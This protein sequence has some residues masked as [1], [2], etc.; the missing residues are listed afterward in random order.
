[1]CDFFPFPSRMRVLLFPSAQWQCLDMSIYLRKHRLLLLR[2]IKSCTTGLV[3]DESH[4]GV[5]C[6]LRWHFQ[7]TVTNLSWAWCIHLISLP[8]HSLVQFD[9]I[10]FWIFFSLFLFSKQ[11][12]SVTAQGWT[13][14]T[15]SSGPSDQ[16]LPWQ[17]YPL[18]KWGSAKWQCS[19]CGQG[20]A[21]SQS[22]WFPQGLM[23]V[24]NI[25]IFC[26]L[27]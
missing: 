26:F 8:S 15:P 3:L 18:G 27:C 14:C 20:Q 25:T 21:T 2:I 12:L 23:A 17:Q 1:M 11:I 6:P 7:P 19:L 24:I 5:D 22:N 16:A 9:W 4:R 13:G 10:S